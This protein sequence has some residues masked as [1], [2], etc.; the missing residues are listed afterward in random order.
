MNFPALSKR[1]PSGPNS[2]EKLLWFCDRLWEQAPLLDF[3][4][5]IPDDYDPNDDTPT[6][7]TGGH[8]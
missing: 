6:A 4:G 3:I 1:L 7:N 5:Q 2:G 8:P